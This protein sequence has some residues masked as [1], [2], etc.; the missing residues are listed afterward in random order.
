MSILWTGPWGIRTIRTH[1]GVAIAEYGDKLYAVFTSADQGGSLQY[2]TYDGE[3]WSEVGDIPGRRQSPS[4]V[5]LAVYRNKLYCVR[6]GTDNYLWYFSFDGTA[7]SSDQRLPAHQTKAG[8]GAAVYNDQLYVV[9]QGNTDSLL[10]YCSFDGATWSGDRY[11][12]GSE[13]LGSSTAAAVYNGSLYT[14]YRGAEGSTLYYR[15]FN[16]ASWSEPAIVGHSNNSYPSTLG[17]ALATKDNV[18]CL[19]HV[20]GPGDDG[21]YSPTFDGTTWSDDQSVGYSTDKAPALG[22]YAGGLYLVWK[23]PN[24]TR[25]SF[26]R[27]RVATS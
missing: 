5:A 9:H 1:D 21:L 26:L 25:T 3:R 22:T 27:G 7:W 14:A 8:P 13:H 19:A 24:D 10:W 15:T 23:E 16:G 17:P 20:G 6:Q 18:L 4:P 12:S 11:V 2:A